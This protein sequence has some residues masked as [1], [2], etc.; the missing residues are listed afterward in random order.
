MEDLVGDLNNAKAEVN[1]AA[2]NIDDPPD[3]V[4][5]TGPTEIDRNRT[6][7]LRLSG[8]GDVVQLVNYPKKA[9]AKII[10]K[11]YAEY[12]PNRLEKANQFLTDLV[13]SNFSHILGELDAIESSKALN[14]ELRNDRLLKKDVDAIVRQLAPFIPALY[15]LSGGHNNTARV[16]PHN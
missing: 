12:K 9:S 6:E 7:L 16:Q 8:G 13:I 4:P 3:P 5:A 1:A 15:I 2:S 10:D 11:V 14:D